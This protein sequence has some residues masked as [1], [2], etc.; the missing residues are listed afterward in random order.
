[1]MA[2]SDA[3]DADPAAAEYQRLLRAAWYHLHEFAAWLP[4]P[5]C[6]ELVREQRERAGWGR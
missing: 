5:E 4:D 1:V 3:Q 2:F 6:V